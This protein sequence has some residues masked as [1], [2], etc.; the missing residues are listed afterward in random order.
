MQLLPPLRGSLPDQA[1]VGLAL[2]DLREVIF[3][4]RDEMVRC[5]KKDFP[6]VGKYFDSK[7]KEFKEAEGQI[8]IH[9]V[10]AS[11]N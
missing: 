3:V 10:G 7:T 9:D 8:S 11:R 5:W 2:L 6:F 4:K 1:E